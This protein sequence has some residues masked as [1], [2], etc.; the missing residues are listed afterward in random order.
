MPIQIAK[1]AILYFFVLG[2]WAF[3]QNLHRRSHAHPN[4]TDVLASLAEGCGTCEKEGLCVSRRKSCPES[5]SSST[6]TTI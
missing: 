3:L 2:F 5:G 1:V 6:A 4:D